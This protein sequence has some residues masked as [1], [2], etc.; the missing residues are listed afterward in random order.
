MKTI[1]A[2]SYFIYKN[3]IF[4]LIA[5]L[6]EDKVF[7]AQLCSISDLNKRIAQL[8]SKI[9]KIPETT[10]PFELESLLNGKAVAKNKL[11][12]HLIF[13]GSDFQNTV[14]ECLLDIPFGKTLSY[15]DV[16][17]KINEPSATRAVASA[18]ARNKIAYFIPCHR[19]IQKN[20]AFGQYR[21]GAE[22]KNDILN[23]EC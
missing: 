19:V 21:W 6:K 7:D 1:V 9:S 10:I 15:S 4:A 3:D 11:S 16:A 12:K 13:D 8:K 17:E 18:I 14:W 20:G 22:L 2:D 5:F 23:Y